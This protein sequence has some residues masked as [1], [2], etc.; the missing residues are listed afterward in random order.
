M[1]RAQRAGRLAAGR[2][3]AHVRAPRASG[4]LPRWTP[5]SGV[6]GAAPFSIPVM[7]I[8]AAMLPTGKVMWFSYPKNPSPRHGGQ[9]VNDPNTAQAWLWNP[10]TG[11]TKR[12]DPPLWRDP[13]DGQLKPANIWCAGQTFTADGRLVVF[14]GNLRFS[15]GSVD[16]KGL[17]K[18]YTFNPFNET[19]TEQPDMRDGRWYPTGVRLADG[20]I[21]VVS[22]LDKSGA[23]FSSEPRRGAVHAIGGHERTRNGQP[24]GH[25]RRGGPAA[26]RRALPAHVRDAVRPNA[27]GGTVPRGQ[28]VAQ[29][30]RRVEQLHLA[31][32]PGQLSRPALGHRSAGARRH[33]MDRRA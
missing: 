13:G 33:R 3:G 22:G 5:R 4:P 21:V 29:P 14:G 28:L 10:A 26:D 30:T 16:Y 25:P 8:H 11:N 12:V 24:A 17:D 2:P 9:G 15:E 27:R 6:V 20:R 32:L 1:R 23:G 7:G 18:I 31:G 19:W